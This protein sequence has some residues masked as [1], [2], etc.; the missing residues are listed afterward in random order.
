MQQATA[1]VET[2]MAAVM[3]ID[4]KALEVYCQNAKRETGQVVEMVNFNAQ[5]QTVIAGHLEAVKTVSSIIQSEGNGK[6]VILPVSVPAHSSLMKPVA[7]ELA[8]LLDTIEIHPPDIPVIQ[9]VSATAFD[10]PEQI[11]N[12]LGRQ[13]YRPV[14]WSET[15]DQMSQQETDYFVEIGPGQVLTGINKR[16]DR[17]LVCYPTYTPER[18]ESALG[19]SD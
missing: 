5:T 12:A 10:S 16:I 18:L 1:E 19:A 13:L 9:N 2:A 14:L 8:S 11:R 15:I 17:K 7:K 3:G 6:V 4:V